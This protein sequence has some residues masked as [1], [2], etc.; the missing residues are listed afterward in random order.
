MNDWLT[1]SQRIC[2]DG[3]NSALGPNLIGERQLAWMVN[4]SV[5][6]GQPRTRP[7]L[8]Q[9]LM[10]PSGKIQGAGFFSID[11]GK[12]ILSIDGEL[13]RVNVRGDEFSHDEIALAWRNSAALDT[14]WMQETSGNLIV[15][16]N[17]SAPIIYD[18]AS[19]RRSKIFENEVPVGSMMAFVN[20]RLWV[21]CYGRN[22]R[23]GNI[24][25]GP[26]TELKFTETDYFVGGGAFYFPEVIRAIAR[27]PA[28]N[29]S[30]GSSGLLVLGRESAK[31]VRS[32]VASRDLWQVM[33]GFITD[34]LDVGTA[35][36]HCVTPVNQDLYWRDAEGQVRS[37]RSAAQESQGASDTG[38]SR[39]VARITDHETDVLLNH[40]SGI[41]FDNRLI[42]TASP[43]RTASYAVGFRRLLVMDCAPLA[44][45]RGKAPPAYDGEW[46]GLNVL[47]LVSGHFDG[48]KRAFAIAEDANGDNSLWEFIPDREDGYLSSGALVGV[49]IRASVESREFDFGLPNNLKRLA[50]CDV[51]PTAIEGDVAVKV[52]WRAANRNQWHL[53]GEFSACAKMTTAAEAPTT[54]LLD[55]SQA[56][57]GSAWARTNVTVTETAAADPN[58][59]TTAQKILES[60]AGS[61]GHALQQNALTIELNKRYDF[62]AYVKR[63]GRRKGLLHLT[64]NDGRSVTGMFDLVDG[65]MTTDSTGVTCA[66]ASILDVGD[67][68]FRVRVGCV[69][70]AS[71][72]A[73]FVQIRF[74][75]DDG[76]LDYAG[77]VA[78]GFYVW[79]ARL[80]LGAP[81]T[82]WKNLRS[83]DRGCVKTLTIPDV[84]EDTMGRHEAVA[85]AFQVRL[86]W[87]GNMELER[88]D[89]WA[90]PL[91]DGSF[92]KV[93]DLPAA[94]V[95][96][97]VSDN[98]VSYSIIPE[99][100]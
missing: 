43:F 20:G 90:K 6:G 3:V 46:S 71:S 53:W 73:A 14:A 26:N 68:W 47:R 34:T 95:E 96:S 86:V 16:D 23:A 2:V 100:E 81:L 88:V 72:E 5:R 63:V 79:N 39:E 64:D 93:Q 66:S 38:I 89:V 24:Y 40:C 55:D 60:G 30:D 99:D 41:F 18:G 59:G 77:D 92:S 9:R 25:T 61:I 57:H 49:P 65:T 21:V 32:D 52:F 78:K 1:F 62:S 27:I 85:H 75:A 84:N 74:Q 67:G 29:T 58:G 76:S 69:F 56:F 17:Q 83:Q 48:N 33:P 45:M 54:Q 22:L 91:K 44:S 98:E 12:I 31:W 80:E 87:T 11:R 36:H 10:L 4:G 51:Y 97:E 13:H 94:C 42:F 8:V 50:R 37:L 7:G 28:K 19:A 35:S 70:P 15:Q 82:R